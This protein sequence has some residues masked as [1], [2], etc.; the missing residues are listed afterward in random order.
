MTQEVLKL[1]WPKWVDW[2]DT[3]SRQ[4][5]LPVPQPRP[6]PERAFWWC[7]HHLLCPPHPQLVTLYKWSRKW[8][9]VSHPRN[10][11]S[12]RIGVTK[13]T[14]KWWISLWLM[15]LDLGDLYPGFTTTWSWWTTRSCPPRTW[16]QPWRC[17][18]PV[19]GWRYRGSCICTKTETI[20][21]HKNGHRW[22]FLELFAPEI[23]WGGSNLHL[24]TS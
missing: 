16:P 3:T 21:G 4:G 23:S 10:L 22:D 6:Y 19:R 5:F 15:P 8:P 1:K 13:P 7:P 24:R 14:P 2:T 9:T 12:L 11:T 20:L 18:T 17:R